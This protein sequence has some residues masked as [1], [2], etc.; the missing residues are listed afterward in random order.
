MVDCPIFVVRKKP[1][2]SKQSRVWI[3]TIAGLLAVAIVVWLSPNPDYR[4]QGVL[5]P[6]KQAHSPLS[7]SS[8]VARIPNPPALGSFV[9]NIS[10]ERHYSASDQKAEQKIW[11][12]AQKLAAEAGANAVV[13]KSLQIS[14]VTSFSGIYLFKA[15]AYYSPPVQNRLEKPQT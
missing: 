8:S 11:G 13:V 6:A 12:L 15:V 10:I 9:G 3:S 5:L 7:P 14:A 4:A 2:V 1:L